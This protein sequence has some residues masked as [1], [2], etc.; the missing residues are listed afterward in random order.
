MLALL[1][2]SFWV[3]PADHCKGRAV[4][5]EKC[6]RGNQSHFYHADC[7]LKVYAL[8]VLLAAPVPDYLSSETCSQTLTT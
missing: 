3:K 8:L 7:V 5:F 6:A 2:S 1:S 4:V